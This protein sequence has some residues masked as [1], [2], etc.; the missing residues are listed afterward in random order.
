MRA[1]CTLSCHRLVVLSARKF[2]INHCS[3]TT[4]SH[5]D[6]VYHCT[7]VHIFQNTI[8]T[9]RHYL[10]GGWFREISV[11]TPFMWMKLLKRIETVV[12]CCMQNFKEMCLLCSSYSSQQTNVFHIPEISI[13]L[14]MKN[15]IDEMFHP[16]E[17]FE[18]L[19]H[20][21]S[22]CVQCNIECYTLG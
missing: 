16:T 12:D 2:S 22:M 10:G 19:N 18:D 7:D 11:V 15:M 14:C 13:L 5:S 21:C 20:V 8:K 1:S 17:I 9:C 6:K 4:E 3:N